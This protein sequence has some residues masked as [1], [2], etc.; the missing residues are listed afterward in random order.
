MVAEYA[1][2]IGATAVVIG[3]PRHGGLAT[4]MDA[5]TSQEVLRHVRTNVVIIN[6]DA[7]LPP[8]A[9]GAAADMAELV[10]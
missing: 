10:S 5:S 1:N 8:A 4:L 3:A 9:P 7:P 6:P 2:K